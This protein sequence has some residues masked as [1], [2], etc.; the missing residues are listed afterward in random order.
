[1]TVDPLASKFARFLKCNPN[2]PWWSGSSWGAYYRLTVWLTTAEVERL[3][4]GGL[5][6]RETTRRLAIIAN[7]LFAEKL[8]QPA[9]AA[10]P[11][12]PINGPNR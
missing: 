7:E 5:S 6:R 10:A 8:R 12:E 3:V 4:G 1:M 2:S 11:A 9:E